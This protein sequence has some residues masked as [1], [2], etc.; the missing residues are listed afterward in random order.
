MNLLIHIEINKINNLH[1]HKEIL[2]WASVR[3]Q[4]LVI[5]D[6]DNHS[7]TFIVDSALKLSREAEKIFL[8]I[9]VESA[10]E[11]AGGVIKFLNALLRFKLKNILIILHG[12]HD[13]VLKMIPAFPAYNLDMDLAAQKEKLEVFFTA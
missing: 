7:D 2:K 5:F 4:E 8:I 1:F 13:V 9:E 11:G 12:N 3:F 10:E 6:F